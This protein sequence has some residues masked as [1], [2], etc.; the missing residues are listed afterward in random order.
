MQQFNTKLCFPKTYRLI[1]KAEFKAIFDN[2]SSIKQ[3]H[4]LVLFK[5]NQKPYAR[6]GLIVKKHKTNN[7]VI[8]NQI[9]RVIRESF[10]LN[11]NLLQG[12]DLIVITRT[13][14]NLLNKIDLRK[15]ID[16]LWKKLHKNVIESYQKP[17]S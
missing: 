8:R 12:L 1:T 3:N 5:L 9:K 16:K 13:E 10:R 11:Q 2:T 17:L 7:A 14:C 6:L 4:L 15:N